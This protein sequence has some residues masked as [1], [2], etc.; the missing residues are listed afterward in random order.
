MYGLELDMKNIN[1]EEAMSIVGGKNPKDG[2]RLVSVRST[3]GS[4]R[5]KVT[6]P[7]FKAGLKK[8]LSIVMEFYLDTDC[9]LK[10]HYRTKSGMKAGEP[11]KFLNAK[12]TKWFRHTVKINDAHF[13]SEED[14]RIDFDGKPPLLAMVAIVSSEQ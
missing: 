8:D 12:T 5:L 10:T 9:T 13:G 4:Y 1:K 14:I 3:D 6:D 2:R 7:D 11:K